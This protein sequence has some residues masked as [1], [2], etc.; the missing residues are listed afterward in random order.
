METKVQQLR[1]QLSMSEERCVTLVEEK[2]QL[3]VVC[4]LLN[5]DLLKKLGELDS[6]STVQSD[7]QD[8]KENSAKLLLT[9][10]KLQSEVIGLQ[11]V[12]QDIEEKLTIAI[13][14]RQQY[15]DRCHELES[16]ERRAP[17][18]IPSPLASE[19]DRINEKLP[20]Q[21][22]SD[23]ESNVPHNHHVIHS[24]SDELRVVE[25][26][27]TVNESGTSELAHTNHQQVQRRSHSHTHTHTHTQHQS[28]EVSHD[29]HHRNHSHKR[30]S[31]DANTQ[32]DPEIENGN[33]FHSPFSSSPPHNATLQPDKEGGIQSAVPSPI[34]S[35]PKYISLLSITSNSGILNTSR[36]AHKKE[37]ENVSPIRS[38]AKS[39]PSGKSM[40]VI[41][42]QPKGILKAIPHS[43]EN[44]LQVVTKSKNS[45]RSFND[46]ES[47]SQSRHDKNTRIAPVSDENSRRPH[48]TG[49]LSLPI[50]GNEGE[51]DMGSS[52]DQDTLWHPS[53][54]T[55]KISR[56]NQD[57]LLLW[58]QQ[59]QQRQMAGM[60][61]MNNLLQVTA[62]M[63]EKLARIQQEKE[64]AL[65]QVK[66]TDKRRQTSEALCQ[67]KLRESALLLEEL[68]EQLFITRQKVSE[69]EKFHKGMGEEKNLNGEGILKI[70]SAESLLPLIDHSQQLQNR[71]CLPARKVKK[72]SIIVGSQSDSSFRQQIP[73][74][75]KE[76]H[77]E[78][79]R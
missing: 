25:V 46:E 7:L 39:A 56:R 9:N 70:A 59:Q 11:Q 20:D 71:N 58:E 50:S 14:E 27:P 65:E 61:N 40:L 1:A 41:N 24:H 48:T 5:S 26:Q 47:P 34:L 76:N 37:V 42:E 36:I 15:C 21:N 49:T 31:V 52:R 3:E 79:S 64:K 22:L 51:I 8:E 75:V 57:L 6:L 63:D 66:L 43:I 60:Q 67:L 78:S 10:E 44:Q 74:P 33:A 13:K 68:S 12:V 28:P 72:N 62:A 35:K 18:L 30:L 55:V 38:Q 4:E 16:V 54:P 23:L 19:V 69:L 77:V 17:T 2:K 73:S 45:R 53:S 29:K 32:T